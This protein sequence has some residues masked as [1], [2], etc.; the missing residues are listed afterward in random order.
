MINNFFL[1][2]YWNEALIFVTKIKNNDDKIMLPPEMLDKLKNSVPYGYSFFNKPSDFDI[3]CIHKD[4][5]DNL[6]FK[7]INE[8][9]KNYYYVFGN[10]VFNI[11]SKNL[12]TAHIS[13]RHHLYNYNEWLIERRQ[14]YLINKKKRFI[15]VPNKII[16][17]TANNMGNAGDDAITHAARKI[18]SKV[19]IKSEIDILRQPISRKL[20]EGSDLVVF[21]GGGI[22][23]DRNL[24]NAINYN[25][26]M[27]IAFESGIPH[28]G[29]GIGTQG[30]KSQIGSTLFRNSLNTSLFTI[31]RDKFD[32]QILEQ[33]DVKTPIL[34]TNDLAFTLCRLVE[35]KLISKKKKLKRVGIVLLDSRK[36]ISQKHYEKYHNETKKLISFLSKKKYQIIYICQSLDDYDLYKNLKINYGGEIR[37]ISYEASK[38]GFKYYNDLDLCITS[39]FHGLIFSAI[40]GIPV[41][42]IGSKNSKIERL[43]KNSL[44]SL[45][46]SYFNIKKF[47]LEN[48]KILIEKYLDIKDKLIV[49]KSELL[50]CKKLSKSSKDLIHRI[51]N[52][53]L[54]YKKNFIPKDKI[55]E[56]SN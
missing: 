44:P 51:Y 11:F 12:K 24:N 29:M 8:I 43:I 7:F 36:L 49:K 17:I 21:G 19:F 31:V 13:D 9:V 14:N 4:H 46:F 2:K 47:S 52:T 33:I 15:S 18:L 55:I 35:K 26:Y 1:D 37:K 22:Y 45:S 27:N 34:L 38:K 30:I 40:S 32:K 10:E 3:I 28:F 48:V 6:S 23:Y 39:R 16:L 25:N 53:T 41:I 50:T 42:S 20:I 56:T 54:L 5:V